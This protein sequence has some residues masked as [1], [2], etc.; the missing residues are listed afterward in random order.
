MRADLKPLIHW[1]V[2]KNFTVR[3]TARSPQGAAGV[4][5]TPQG[6][7]TFSYDAARRV[8]AL[9]D[10]EVTLNEHGWEVTT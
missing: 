10:R 3:F 7:V 5:T 9:P 8:I 1:A 4:L 6:V 2:Y